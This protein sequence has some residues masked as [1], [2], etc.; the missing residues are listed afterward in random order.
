M[1]Y[2]IYNG[3]VPFSQ[4]PASSLLQNAIRSFINK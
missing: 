4:I 2:V 1:R 3:G